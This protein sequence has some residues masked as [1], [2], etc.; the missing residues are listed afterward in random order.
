LRTHRTDNGCQHTSQYCDMCDP[1]SAD[2]PIHEV[3]GPVGITTKINHSYQIFLLRPSGTPAPRRLEWLIP[4][5]SNGGRRPRVH[6]CDGCGTDFDALWSKWFRA[7]QKINFSVSRTDRLL[8]CF[9]IEFFVVFARDRPTG[10]SL[11]C[12]GADRAYEGQL[13]QTAAGRVSFI[14][15][16]TAARPAAAIPANPENATALPK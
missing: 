1:S 9:P 2:K 3:Q 12:N 8:A 7:R 4:L 14:D 10:A 15:V 5:W 6:P 16:Q 11:R 13:V